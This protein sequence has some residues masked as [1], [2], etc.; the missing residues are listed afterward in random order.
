MELE[1]DPFLKVFLKEGGGSK[2]SFSKVVFLSSILM[3]YIFLYILN[4]LRHPVVF[5]AT[6]LSVISLCDSLQPQ[7]L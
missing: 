5:S 3:I 6:Q 2:K 7:R 4:V 1:S